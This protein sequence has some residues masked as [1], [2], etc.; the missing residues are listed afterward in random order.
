VLCALLVVAL[1]AQSI[2]LLPL[3]L[4]AL[5]TVAHHAV[6]VFFVISGFS[7]ASAAERATGQPGKFLGA[8]LARVY[9]TAAPALLLA[10]LLDLSA[11]SQHSDLYPT[12]QYNKWWLHLGFHSLFLGELW[13]F[14]LHPFSIIPY[15]SLSYEVW[16]YLLLAA[17]LVPSRTVRYCA[18]SLVLLAMGPKLWLLLPCWLLGVLL[19][20]LHSRWPPQHRI[21]SLW[22]PSFVFAAGYLALLSLGLNDWQIALGKVADAQF[23]MLGYSKWCLIDTAIAAAFALTLWCSGLTKPRQSTVPSG[24]RK[25]VSWLAPHTY[26][27][28]LLHYTLLAAMK[29]WWFPLH[30]PPVPGAAAVL[31]AILI[32]IGISEAAE[33]TRWIWAEVFRRLGLR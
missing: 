10:L 29:M 28:Y 13:N 6:I 4:S 11:G 2:G 19:F 30:T 1:H 24:Q 14:H 17:I 27:I 25:F 26:G 20:R 9:A 18:A 16:Y 7:V 12:W 32:S 31:A 15:W 23:S 21:G 22:W 3:G 5:Y 8:R 33:R